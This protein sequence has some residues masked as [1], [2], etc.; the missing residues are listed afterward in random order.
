MK[1]KSRKQ[2]RKIAL[3]S[4]DS[5]KRKE[6][7]L[8][9]GEKKISVRVAIEDKDSKV[10]NAAIKVLTK[11]KKAVKENQAAFAAIA[12]KSNNEA[13]A[14]KAS[15]YLLTNKY[16]AYVIRRTDSKKVLKSLLSKF[17][18]PAM[19]VNMLNW[20]SFKD[21]KNRGAS[22]RAKRIIKRIGEID[23]K[24]LI[25]VAM[26]AKYD[27]IKILAEKSIKN[28]KLIKRLQV[29]RKRID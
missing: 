26:A 21:S 22:S 28:K 4:R 2:L 23:E 5:A 25:G 11:T 16:A 6:A 1:N 27:Y 24:V 10:R 19:L 18:S 8:A 29:I 9:L 3:R 12:I 14:A 15:G 7:I 17:K 20:P 13:T